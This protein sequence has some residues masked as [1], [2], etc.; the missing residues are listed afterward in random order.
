MLPVN[1]MSSRVM[2]TH[3]EHFH[4]VDVMVN[5]AGIAGP[6]EFVEDISFEQWQ[7]CF[8]VNIDAVFLF[9]NQVV[10]FH[11]GSAGWQHYQHLIDARAGTA[12]RCERLMPHRNGR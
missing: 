7:R 10:P 8:A 1:P 11:E 12:T 3:I 2:D 4:G 5:C 6:T 9:C